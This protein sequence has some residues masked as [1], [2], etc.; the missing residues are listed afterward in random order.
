MKHEIRK[1][2]MVACLL[3]ALSVKAES[4]DSAVMTFDKPETAGISGFRAMWDTPIIL[5]ESGMI[6]EVTNQVGGNFMLQ[7]P[8]AFWAP[9]KRQGG[10]EPGA[11][12]FDAVHRSLLLRFP[13]SAEAVAAKLAE[14]FR[15]EKA[16]IEL[17]FINTE[18]WPE[19]Y[20]HPCGMS[21]LRD[22]WVKIPP[23]WHA[24]AWALRKPWKADPQLGPT[25]NSA[26]NG[27]AYWKRFGAQDEAADR[28]PQ[29]FGPV[30]VS[31]RQSA[32]YQGDQP[33]APVAGPKNK[34]LRTP[35]TPPGGTPARLD[36]TAALNDAAFGKTP[37][38]RLRQFED[39]G[40]LV[41]KEEVYD[42]RYHTGT[43]EWSTATGR[44]GILIRTPKFVITFAPD[45]KAE[46]A[47]KLPPPADI[48]ALAQKLK[49]TEEGG[50][51][52]AVMPSSEQI[53]EWAGRFGFRRPEGMPDWQWTRLEELKKMGG[54]W[55]FPAT[56]EAYGKWIDSLLA[57]PPRQ[58][59]GH[60]TPQKAINALRFSDAL[61]E[62]VRENEFRYFES[63][64]MPWMRTDEMDHPQAIAMWYNKENRHWQTTH[65]WRG[66]QSYYRAGYT[67]RITTMNINHLGAS[68]A[69]FGGRLVGCE[70]AMADGRYGL[71]HFPLR[72]WAW[73]DGT[74]QESIDHY[75]LPLTLWTQ[76]EFA[77]FGP[78]HLDRMMGQSMLAKTVDEVVSC[79]H[80]GLRRFIAP[81]NR[82]DLAAILLTQTGLKYL[83]HSMSRSGA[84]TDLDNKDTFGMPIYD[85]ANVKPGYVADEWLIGPWAPGWTPNMVDEKPLPYEMTAVQREYPH[86]Q[87]AEY[88]TLKCSYMGKHY[89]LASRTLEREGDYHA[90]QAG[91]WWRRADKQ[92]ARLDEIVTMLVRPEA[93]ERCLDWY[94]ALQWAETPPIGGLNANVQ[95]KNILLTLT[96]PL[97]MRKKVAPRSLQTVL[98][99]F[100]FQNPPTWEVYV[101]GQPVKELPLKAKANQRITIHDGVSYVGLIPVPATDLGRDAEIEISS[102]TK[103]ERKPGI[104]P[105][106][107]IRNYMLK[108]DKPLDKDKTDWDKVDRAYAGFVIEMGDAAEFADFAAFQKHIAAAVLEIRE[109][110]A[111]GIVHFK[112][113]NGKDVM[114][115]GYVPTWA[116]GPTAAQFPYRRVNGGWPW[117]PDGIDRNTTLTQQGSNGKLEKGGAI[118]TCEPGRMAYLQTEPISGTFC[119]WNPLPDPTFWQM[120]LP[121][122]VRAEADG[123]VSILRVE[124]QPAQ[125]CLKVDYAVKEEQ[126]SEDMATSL[127]VFGM[128]AD[129]S[130]SF[131]GAPLAAK[132]ETADFGGEKALVIPLREKPLPATD[133]AK[134]YAAIIP[135]RDEAMKRSDRQIGV[136]RVESDSYIYT[137]P[138]SGMSRFQRLWPTQ[139]VVD[140]SLP[141]GVRL[142]TD[143]RVALLRM[144]IDR[145]ANM[146]DIVLPIYEQDIKELK[147]KAMLVFGLDKA[148][149][150][151][152]NGKRLETPVDSTKIGD[153]TAYVIPLFGETSETVQ[154]GL[155]DRFAAAQA[156]LSVSEGKKQKE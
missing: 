150:A 107:T 113:D 91:A 20:D 71:E 156:K 33:P 28:F 132:P 155:A 138:Q 2:A 109:D 154:A 68:G 21:F 35:D 45:A 14:G 153:R 149:S 48:A 84:F 126:V 10:A 80:P 116:D 110:A 54:G 152:I 1:I 17:P 27:A 37:A 112:Y 51:P 53:A 95:Y 121:G 39:C 73:S 52:T 79:Y 31:Y 104:L 3:S 115:V 40:L 29:R 57:C 144:D 130:I 117:P 100:N 105:G 143:G 103:V 151:V 127:L 123:R 12:V 93:D 13:G 66:N 67:R 7:G 74:T 5:A 6:G 83:M 63:W 70:E 119:G 47:G 96:S 19:G 134:R 75:Y 87:E 72:L 145:T 9:D 142:A 90:M 22:E 36:V 118:L 50:T 122:G 16:E 139:S 97:D 124:I 141:D 94:G 64:A 11:L 101:D 38:E 136:M 55:D 128:P 102:G 41:R 146:I 147:A 125:K 26:I 25:Y 114:E 24:V 8:S 148:P 86:T 49:G 78:T 65:D 92:V 43:Y 85:D 76:K 15:I 120:A 131:N 58:W 56:P 82:T 135:Q 129:S 4:E 42:A 23:N 137:V 133:L 99:L 98:G 69:L 59:L 81:S 61:P 89:G 88:Q 46:K 106:L 111:A 108:G 44:R 18:L 140:A 30:E 60:V 77:D 32:N 34:A 62:V